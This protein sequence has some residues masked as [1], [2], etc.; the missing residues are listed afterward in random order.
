MTPILLPNCTTNTIE[1]HVANIDNEIIIVTV[2]NV[3]IIQGKY[4]GETVTMIKGDKKNIILNLKK[5]NSLL[6][7]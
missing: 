7:V 4:W 6:K 1:A 3:D 2:S 5:K